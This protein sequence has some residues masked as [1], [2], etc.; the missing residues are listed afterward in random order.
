MKNLIKINY[1]LI[2]RSISCVLALA[3][4]LAGFPVEMTS[5]NGSEIISFLKEVKAA[6]ELAELTARYS[7]H[8]YT[9]TSGGTE[10]SEYSQC[11]QDSLWAVEHANDIITLNPVA[12]VFVFDTNYS[13]IGSA[14]APFNG[15]IY[16]NTSAADFAVNAN[17]SIFDYVK[18]SVSLLRLGSADD[19]IPLSI[20]RVA[21]VDDTVSPLFAKHVVGSGAAAPY[22]WK[23]TLN[24]AS[25][26]SYSGVIF[27]M[28]DGAKVNLTF[29]DK[30]NHTPLRDNNNVIVSG[31]IIDNKQNNA[32]YGILCGVLKNGSVLNCTYT[33]VND[34]NVT[35]IGTGIAYTGGLVGEIDGS[36]FEILSGSSNLKVDFQTSKDSVGFICGH[37]YN[38]T[39]TLPDGYAISGTVDG[40]QYAGGIVGYCKNTTINYEN[41]TG[42]INISNCNISNGNNASATGGVFGYY[43]SNVKT[44][45]ILINNHSYILTNCTVVGESG[46]N[47][48]IA[49]EYKPTYNDNVTIDLDKY[50]LG[51]SISLSGSIAGGLF[52][53]YTSAGNVTITDSNTTNSHFVPSSS[54][55]AYGGVIG[56]YVNGSTAGVYSQTLTLSDFVVNGINCTSTGNVGGVLN[57]LTGS[58]YIS[59]DDV[60][61]TNASVDASTKFG[62]IVSTLNSNNIGSFIDLTGDFTVSLS[63]GTYKGGAVAGSFKNGVIR[64]AGTTDISGAR[65]ANGYGQ[66]VYENDNTLVYALGSGSDSRWNFIRNEDTTTSDLGQ[67]GEV[68]RLFKVNGADKNAEEAGIVSVSGNKV[69][70]AGVTVNPTIDDEVSFAKV[71]LNMQLNDGSDH[72]SLCFASGGANKNALLSTDITVSGTVDLSGTGL[73]GLMRDGGLGKYLGGGDNTFHNVAFFTGSVTGTNDAEIKLTT[74]EAYGNYNSG[75][76]GTGGKIYLSENYGHDAQGLFA[77]AKGVSIT[78]LKVSGNIDVERNGGSNYLYAGALFGAMTNGATL[79]GT[80]VTTTIDA[81]RANNARFYIGGVSGVFDGNETS[82]NPY[83]LSIKDSSI[84]RPVIVLS[85][86]IGCTDS[87]NDGDLSKCNNTYAGGV[88]GLLKGATATRYGVS[89]NS[90]EIS[91]A[92]TIDSRV[93]DVDYSYLGG[94]IGRVSA[95]STNQRT[96]SI[97]NVGMTNAAVQTKA[98]YAGGL[99]G[100]HWERTNVTIDGLTISG[101]SVTHSYSAGGSKMSGLVFKGTGKWDVNTLSMSSTG[102]TSADT[103]A[104]SFG[105][106]VNEAYSGSDGL[107]I[108]LKNSGYTLSGVTIPTSSANGNYYVDEIV[109]DSQNNDKSGG[110]ILIGKDGTG[111]VNINMNAVNGADTKITSTGTYQNRIYSQLNTLNLTANQNSRYYYNLDVIL[112]KG[113]N[114]SGATDG[115]KFLLWSVRK[116]ASNNIKAYFKS[117]DDMI[118]GTDIDLRGL[119]YYPIYGDNVTLPTGATVTFGF[120]AI[121]DYEN[122]TVTP[123]N[124]SRNPDDAG[125]PKTSDARNQHYLMQ[126]GL[127]NTTSSLSADRLTLTGDFGYVEG[128]ASGA[129]INGSTSGSVTVTGLTLDK[130]VPSNTSSYMLINYINGT[131]NATPS[132]VVSGV[133]AENYNSAGVTLPVAKSLFGTAMGQ[134]MTMT[135]SD[136]KLDARNGSTITDANWSADATNNAASMTAAYGTSRSIFSTAT[137]FTT[138]LSSKTSVMI[139]NYGVD[140]DWEGGAPRN[141]T[142]GKEITSSKQY[143]SGEEHY[144]T[145]GNMTGNY[146]NPI[147]NSNTR[148]NFSAGFLPYVGNYEDKGDDPTYPVVEIKVNYKAPGIVNGCGTYNDPYIISSASQLELVADVVNGEDSPSII[149]LPNEFYTDHISTSWHNANS[150]DGLY[151]LD[152][153]RYVKDT[154]NSAKGLDNKWTADNVRLYLAAAYYLIDDDIELTS[155][156]KGIGAPGTGTAVN[157]N[158]VF[159]G[160]IIGKKIDGTAPTIT[161]PTDN[162]FIYISNGSVVKNINIEVETAVS[163]SLGRTGD[164][165]LYGYKKN[166]ST[167]KGAE[168]YG[169]VIGEIMGGDNII[170]DVSIAYSGE[171]SL[172]GNYSHLIAEGGMVGVVVNGSL[173]FRGSN[174]VSGRS[175]SGGG[176]YSNPYVG[177]VINGYAI[178]EKISGRPGTAPV[179][180]SYYPI[181]SIDRTNQNKLDVNYDDGTIDIPDAQALYI[182][183]L[184]T[185]SIAGTAITTG[186]E[187]YT[188]GSNNGY[189]P[190]YGFWKQNYLVGVARLGDY[191]EVGCG[192]DTTKPKDYSSFAYRDSVNNTYTNNGDLMWSPTPYIIYRYTKA[193]GTNNKTSLNFPARKM[194]SDNDKF[195]NINLDKSNTFIDFDRY[196]AFRGIGSVGIISQNNKSKTAMKIATFDGNNNTIKFHISLPRYERYASNKDQDNY[197]HKQNKSLTQV[198]DGVQLDNA[199]Y[200]HDGTNQIQQLMGLGLF[201]CVMVKNDSTHEYQFCNFTLQGTIEDKVYNRNGDDITG[202]TDQTQ[203]FC[204]GGVIG[205]RVNGNNYDLNFSNITFDG[206]T[207]TGAYNCGGLIGID[208]V[209]SVTKMKID[210]CNSTTN[211]ISLTG[212]YYGKANALRHGVG[213]F[214]GM[215]FWCRPYINGQTSNSAT[216]DIYVAN[217]S[218]YYTGN[219]NRCNVGGLIG[220]SGTGAEIKNIRLVAAN[221]NSVVG[222]P[223]VANAAGFIGYAQTRGNGNDGWYADPNYLS[224]SIYIENCTLDNV[225]VKA[226]NSAAGFYGRSWLDAWS[227]KYIFIKDCAVV[228]DVNNKPEIK[229]YGTGT[230]NDDNCVGGFVS[231]FNGASTL[232]IS[233]MTNCH[234]EGYRLEGYNVG[235]LIGRTTDKTAYLKNLYSRDCEI[236]TCNANGRVGGIVGFSNQNLSGYNLKIDNVNFYRR[237]NNTLSDFTSNAGMVV[238]GH[239]STNYIYKFI[240]IGGYHSDNIKVPTAVVKYYG[241]NAGNLF[242]YS[243]YLNTGAIDIANKNSYVSTF[244]NDGVNVD[245]PLAP[246][247]NVAPHMDMGTDEYLTGDGASIGKAGEIYKDIKAATSNRRYTIRTS[248]VTDPSVGNVTDSVTMAKYINDNGTY[249]DGTFKIS[250]AS[251]EFKD[252]FNNLTGVD[253]FS[254]LVINDDTDKAG[255][256]TPFIK[257]YIRMVTNAAAGYNSNTFSQYAYSCGNTTIDALYSV[258]INPCYYDAGQGKF[259]LG[260]A[261]DQGLQ[262]YSRSD[263]TDGGKYYFDSSKADSESS[264]TCQ[265]SLIDVQFKDPTDTNSNRVAYHLYVPV[266]TKKMLTVEF[267]A[268]TMS[269]TKYNR[270]LY[271]NKITSEIEAGKNT[272][273]RS[274]LVESTNEWTTTFIRYTYPKNQVSSSD[275]WNFDKT[276]TLTLDGNFRTLPIGTKLILVDPNANSDKYYTMTIGSEYSTNTAIPLNLSS[277]VDE[278]G[279]SFT[280]QNLSAIL[281]DSEASGNG[282]GHTNELYEDYYI[283]MYVPKN[284]GATHSILF[285]C[286]AELA[287]GSGDGMVKANIDSKLYSLVILG[288]LFNHSIVERGFEVNSGDGVTFGDSPEMLPT[289]NVLKSEVT[290]TV[291]IKNQSAGA[292]LANSDVYH[293]FFISLT[294]HDEEHKVSD[295]IY[296]ITPGYIN[297]TTT[298]TYTNSSGEHSVTKTESRLGANYIKLDSG[299]IIAA[300]YDPTMSPVVTIHAETTMTFN[301]VTAFPFNMNGED[302]IGTQVSIKSNLAYR[303][304]DLLFSAMNVIE[305]DPEGTFYYSKTKNSAELSFNAVPSDDTSDEIGLKTNNRNLLGVNGK[306]GT[307]HPILGMAIYNVD[308]IVDYDSSTTLKYTV[309]LYKKVTDVNGTRYVQVD[310]ISDYLSSV[311]MEDHEVTLTADRTTNPAEYV[312]TGSINHEHQSDLDRMFETDFSCNVLTGDAGHNE[313]ANYKIYITAELIGATNSWKDA[314]LIYTN[315]K[316]DPSVIDQIN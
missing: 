85:G 27:E 285:G 314:Y 199:D 280:P 74:G 310:D 56:E 45:D 35:F 272:T 235:G 309:A 273:N 71:A 82:G 229:A 53:K 108:N 147:G 179:N 104:A 41:T 186:N 187:D 225:S 270:A 1:R 99:L 102:I 241:T 97:N 253:N 162:P 120:K 107:Y 141:V 247:V 116:Y 65:A 130:L 112:A 52:G 13:P 146:T 266:Y 206:L 15:T 157:G 50:S 66:L 232:I 96:I 183:S 76:V 191:D 28:T 29:D 172:S 251:A 129:L 286:E 304:E 3:I 231:G 142:Y 217:V 240:G 165:A 177:R 7:G 160:V 128:I 139:Y 93:S 121:N 58:T 105:L 106:I 302:E 228:G 117:N 166:N 313:Y 78:D 61:I 175:V 216:S 70:V 126:T 67:W 189:S 294:S 182:M 260:E 167:D 178:Y 111:I 291:Q 284:E 239:T 174:S 184:I 307:S 238:G 164:N 75:N 33:K 195:W 211:G 268:V 204:L 287:H 109:A 64:F 47:G 305:E 163:K 243:D 169:G 25:A 300:L 87:Y 132:L 297:N 288:D 123:D 245:Q 51:N 17:S 135:F 263:T 10:L 171:T 293:A 308:D 201:D 255:D 249:K 292:Y 246:F 153:G 57:V 274:I 8:T 196:Q 136:I 73:L 193:Y 23:V 248:S 295:I 100:S 118:S 103:N 261:G 168:Y 197:F 26:R 63:S 62:G 119:S 34:D 91:P 282:A 250:T 11:F 148:F 265:F 170:D 290:A 210:G 311:D 4:I 198:Y 95:N 254:M 264:N 69:T 60:S 222:A 122:S 180:S 149:T 140:E 89:I 21:D 101:A 83:E 55:V 233:E 296:G 159:H 80:T 301:D 299:S 43:E 215:T 257:S 42:I 22:E 242:V 281:A 72:G 92:I 154:T 306:Y 298:Y 98:K 181:D 14:S 258:V 252:A 114:G 59:V 262:M 20:N 18:D 218:T 176:I 49:G 207:I 125:S 200:G 150:G 68:V 212:G 54:T 185:Q 269:E 244:G 48:G 152:N 203:L 276:I 31:S 214:V 236:I 113:T 227:V 88:L 234:I 277:F 209:K 24:S 84:I 115:E 151:N 90:S 36:T 289:N 38:S 77:F 110:D 143:A 221:N 9:F 40:N 224:N 86:V 30:S 79:S 219:D 259:V 19:N 303:E 131:G 2:K 226:K 202:T 279:N 194:T 237:N 145:V 188:D 312:F 208:A 223:N 283:S 6:G 158:Y 205:K 230:N 134:N 137:F 192:I 44:N 94:M 220:T 138:L 316:F 267:S 16:F 127:F 271:A 46:K 190:S 315:A 278:S 5:E 32:N 144:Y 37:A 133:R 155:D 161:N 81:T 173:I 124:W 12:G 39:I 213:S 275:G 256:I 156:F